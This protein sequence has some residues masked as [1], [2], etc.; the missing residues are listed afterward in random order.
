MKKIHVSYDN[1]RYI[2][3]ISD[4]KFEVIG[5][6][7]ANIGYEKD[8]R[9]LLGRKI[10]SKNKAEVFVLKNISELKVA[11]ICNWHDQCGISTYS[12]FLTN[13]I[14]GKV[15][16]VRIFSES[17]NKITDKDELIV[18]RC[19]TRGECLLP[20]VKKVKEW[21]PDF[22][23]IQHEYGIFPNA[24][25]FMQMMQYF[26]NIPYVVALHS[27]Y[28]H[29]DKVVY[30][31]CIKNIVVHTEQGKEKLI[32]M[33]NTNNI[34]V[35]PHGCINFPEA[36]E[37]WNICHNPYTIMQFGFGFNYKG[38]E[39]ALDA[40]HH[41]KNTDK[42]F[43]NIFYFYL[44]SDNGHTAN[45]HK[46]YYNKLME[47]IESLELQPNIAIIRKYQ[48]DE[49]LNLYLRLA[50]IAIFPYINNPNNTVYAASG[51]IRVAMA[52]KIPVIA[53]ASHL[54][55]DL[56]NIVP[57]P[58]NYLDLAK[59]IDSIFSNSNYR[60]D[61]INKSQTFITGNSWD[62]TAEKYLSLYLNC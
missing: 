44:L 14:V 45:I 23:I 43:K 19:W 40:I 56:E 38:V 62:N 10:T 33:G 3:V 11:I 52:N 5:Q 31:S 37:I 17:S 59:Y 30:S 36:E 48:S 7:T 16:E 25:Y 24:F 42:K 20:M 49:M 55:D 57:R 22:I 60:N 18:D 39:V 4:N 2:N 21:E 27:V 28:E 13:A 29:L 15:K 58:D 47:K 53:S 26:D 51:A 46:E 54:F 32:K 12:H 34:N 6:K 1:N 41:L 61:L 35:I 8:I 9:N 50:K